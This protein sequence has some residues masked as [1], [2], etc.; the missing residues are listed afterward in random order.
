MGAYHYHNYDTELARYYDDKFD[1][2]MVHSRVSA[3]I[4]LKEFHQKRDWSLVTNSTAQ[5]DVILGFFDSLGY[6][7]AHGKIS[8]DVLYEYFYSDIDGYYRASETYI[9]KQQKDESRTVFEFLQ[10]LF[11]SV[12]AIELKKTGKQPADLVWNEKDFDDWIEEEIKLQKP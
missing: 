8:P 6:D 12:T 5:L 7:E 9:S 3:A 2:K 4:A 1:D 10:P 11:D